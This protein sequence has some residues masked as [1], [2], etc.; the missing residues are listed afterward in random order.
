MRATFFSV[1]T[2]GVSGTVRQMVFFVIEIKT[3]A[4]H[5]AGIR[6]AMRDCSL[7]SL[8]RKELAPIGRGDITASGLHTL[9]NRRKRGHA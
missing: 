3:R 2:P 9:N 5:L 1:E 7:L 6:V 4:I 8:N